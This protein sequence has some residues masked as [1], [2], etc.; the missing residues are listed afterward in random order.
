MNIENLHLLMDG[1]TQEELKA[2]NSHI[3]SMDRNAVETF[4][5]LLDMRFL[6]L[7]GECDVP[8]EQLQRIE[9]RKQE[10]KDLK[11]SIVSAL[12]PK[13]VAPEEEYTHATE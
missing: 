6:S 10:L 3:K 4:L 11:D 8:T 2:L 5:T 13:A 12:Q 7:T 9:G 1:P